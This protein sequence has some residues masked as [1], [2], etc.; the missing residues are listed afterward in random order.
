MDYIDQLRRLSIHADELGPESH[1]VAATE[2][3]APR[4][5]AI[6]RFAALVAMGGTDASFS[7]AADEAARAQVSTRELVQVILGVATFVGMPRTVSAAQ[8]LL[9]ALELDVETFVPGSD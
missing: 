9:V 1:S 5:R 4:D 7:A 6:V 2:A 8:H 3:L